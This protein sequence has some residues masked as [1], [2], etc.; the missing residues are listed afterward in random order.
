[1]FVPLIDPDG[2]A[3]SLYNHI[4]YGYDPNPDQSVREARVFAGF[5]QEWVNEGKRLDIVLNLH[6]VESA[7]GPALFIPRYETGRQQYCAVLDR[8]IADRVRAFDIRARPGTG[9]HSLRT[10]RLQ[11]FLARYTGSLGML[12]EVNSQDPEHHLTLE[13]LQMI[14]VGMVQGAVQYVYSREAA[15]LI[16]EINQHRR[17]RSQNWKRYEP[18]DDELARDGPVRREHLYDTMPDWERFNLSHGIF[19]R[20]LRQLY[21]AGRQPLKD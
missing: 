3:Q 5:F 1:L 14:G 2:A 7:E 18:V 4:T 20:L 10:F 15:P 21:A 11:G 9:R 12:Y 16:A 8:L 13:Q 6:N 19:P 17:V